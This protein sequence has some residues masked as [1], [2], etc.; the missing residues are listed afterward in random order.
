MRVRLI[1]PLVA[2]AALAAAPAAV[3]AQLSAYKPSTG[4]YKVESNVKVAQTMMGQ[5][6]EFETNSKQ[7]LTIAITGAAPTMD[8]SV[9]LDSIA[10]TS[11]APGA[12]T[13]QSAMLGTKVTAKL[14]AA[15]ATSDTKA[16]DK[17]G[18]EV[19]NPAITQIAS[20][21]PRLKPGAKLGESWV[22]TTKTTANQ[23]G[24]ETTTNTITTYTYASDTTVGSA[25]MAKVNAVSTA[26]I[27]GKGNAQ[28]QDIS[29]DGESKQTSMYLV[30]PSG[31]L[32]GGS[33]NAEINMSITVEAMGLV[34]PMTQKVMT[35]IDKVS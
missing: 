8:M 16:V 6:Q 33:G 11:T 30:A 21:L 31:A 7:Q 4:K 9:V 2:V 29:L 5:T 25:K 15:G 1:A 13:D 34:I 17:T 14:S 19:K 10:V 23:N 24:I 20:L 28:G 32:T 12:N 22:D 3:D 18:A 27:T 26:K 35:K